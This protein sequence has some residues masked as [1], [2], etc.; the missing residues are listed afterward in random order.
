MATYSLWL[1]TYLQRNLLAG[2]TA[3]WNELSTLDVT[4]S[5]LCVKDAYRLG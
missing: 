2:W 3:C 4:L 5:G 1:K